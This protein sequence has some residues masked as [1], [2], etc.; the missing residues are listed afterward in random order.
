MITNQAG[1]LSMEAKKL[2]GQ[3]WA[4]KSA[5]TERDLKLWNLQ[6][7]RE[8]L[9]QQFIIDVLDVWIPATNIGLVNFNDGILGIF[10]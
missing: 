10:G 9:R 4:E 3:T 6:L 8:S 7:A 2:Q 1:R 5:E